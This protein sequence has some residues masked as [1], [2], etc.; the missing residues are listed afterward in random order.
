VVFF[1]EGIKSHGKLFLPAGFSETGNVPAVV[2]APGVGQLATTV[3]S[4]AS[5]IAQRGMAAMAIDYRGWGKSGA[6]IYLADPVRWDDRLRFSQHTAKVK[7]RRR[8]IHPEAQVIDI[9][10]AITFLQGEPGID[11]ARIGVW[12]SGLSGAHVVM[13]AANDARLK[14]GAAVQRWEDGKGVERRAFA[15]SAAQQAA[16]VRLARSGSVPSGDAAAA[17]MNADESKLAFAEYQPF[18]LLDQIPKGTAMLY[19]DSNAGAIVKAA[20]FFATELASR[21]F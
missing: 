2:V 8:R 6:L 17:A 4:Q 21:Q 12:G 19:L 16:M 3:E 14:A 9:R 5:A 18:R 13:I 15:P 20:E 11:A 1:S 7:L 10:N